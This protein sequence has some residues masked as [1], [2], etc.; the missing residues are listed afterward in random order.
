MADAITEKEFKAY[1]KVQKSGVTNM[2][3]VKTV[4]ALSGLE[5]D[6]VMVIMDQY[7]ELA[8]KFPKV[9]A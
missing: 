2:M 9:V 7:S 6:R 8:D 5:R 3:M 4:C 1:V